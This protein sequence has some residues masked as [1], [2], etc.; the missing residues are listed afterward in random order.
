MWM[1]GTTPSCDSSTLAGARAVTP[2]AVYSISRS[3]PSPS[4]RS[5]VTPR[6][7][8]TPAARIS[9]SQARPLLTSPQAASASPSHGS[10]R[11]QPPGGEVSS[12][13]A[14]LPPARSSCAMY[15]S[16]KGPAARHPDRIGRHLARGLEQDLRGA[17]GQH[18]GQGPA[19]ERRG[20]FLRAQRQHHANGPHHLG[21]ALARHVDMP[22]G[23]DLPDLGVGFVER[24]TGAEA[25]RQ[26]CAGAVL[27]AQ[28]AAGG[29][30]GRHRLGT[31]RQIWPPGAGC[32][33]TTS[34]VRPCVRRPMAAL[35]PAGPAPIT[36]TSNSRFM[37]ARSACRTGAAR[38]CRRAR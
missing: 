33:S 18:A 37:A 26:A 3:W 8:L 7:R 19:R 24:A 31:A 5:A 12:Q 14:T 34:T 6:T 13:P 36:T 17:H 29:A 4:A 10:A 15:S 38:A 9:R 2:P 30:G 27:I 35:M 25:F 22:V 11:R 16:G 32:S 1:D 20:P 23:F 21:A 28:Q